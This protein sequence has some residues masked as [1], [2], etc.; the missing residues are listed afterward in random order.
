MKFMD[1]ETLCIEIDACI[2]NLIAVD[3]AFTDGGSVLPK[4]ALHIPVNCLED[5][6]KMLQEAIYECMSQEQEDFK[7]E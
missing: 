6:F 2:G 7:C 3:I 4:S 1:L 5:N